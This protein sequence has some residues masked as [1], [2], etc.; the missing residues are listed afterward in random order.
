MDPLLARSALQESGR[1]GVSPM[2]TAA[3]A[4]LSGTLLVLSTMGCVHDP[5]IGPLYAGTEEAKPGHARIYLYRHDPHHSFSTVE[6]RFDQGSPLQ[7]LDEEYITVELEEGVHEVEFRLRRRIWGPR[8][9]WRNQRIRARSGDTLFFEIAVGVTGSSTHT[10][11]EVAIAG[12]P[13]GTASESVSVEMKSEA[14]ATSRI[15]MTHLH[16]P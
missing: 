2:S 9:S 11:R 7:I 14:E 5:T 3:V 4:L 6:V 16:V 8:W 1:P 10:G 15:R 13:V 12:R